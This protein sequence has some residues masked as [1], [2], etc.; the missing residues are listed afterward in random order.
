MKPFQAPKKFKEQKNKNKKRLTLAEEGEEMITKNVQLEKLGEKLEKN[1]N[2]KFTKKDVAKIYDLVGEVIEEGILEGGVKV[3]KLF[4]VT[5]AQRAA[6]QG[7]NPQTGE[8]L[9]I[10]SKRVARFK[11]SR[12]LADKVA[13]E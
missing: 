4:T 9:N 2:A 7:R 12:N 13:A 3:G 1:L 6:R 10:P 5:V 8:K 11:A